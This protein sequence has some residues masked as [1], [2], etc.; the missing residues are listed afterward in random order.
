MLIFGVVDVATCLNPAWEQFHLEPLVH[1]A[2]RLR[3]LQ[4]AGERGLNGGWRLG[5]K[6]GLVSMLIC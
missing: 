2:P 1:H 6:K 3:N 5:T 4:Q